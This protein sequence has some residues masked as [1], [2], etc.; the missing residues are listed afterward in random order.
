M[1]KQ[2]KS[3]PKEVKKKQKGR[4]TSKTAAG[5]TNISQET[6]DAIINSQKEGAAL[7]EKSLKQYKGAFKNARKWVQ[8]FD[9]ETALQDAG[10]MDSDLPPE[11]AQSEFQPGHHIR[12]DPE[13]HS[14][15]N[16]IYDPD[17]KKSLDGPPTRT[18]PAAMA[19]Y[20]S[21]QI[22]DEGFGRSTL[23]MIDAAFKNHYKSMGNGRYSKGE[24]RP[25]DGGLTEEYIGCP[26]TANEYTA[27]VGHLK[28]KIVE[29]GD[30]RHHSQPMTIE[31]VRKLMAY[32]LEKCP[33][34]LVDDLDKGRIKAEDFNATRL[35]VVKHL[36]F[37]AYLTTGWTLWTRCSELADLR[38]ADITFGHT[39]PKRPTS[40]SIWRK[41]ARVRMLRRKGWTLK[42]QKG[43]SMDDQ[44]IRGHA[45]NI[46]SDPPEGIEVDSY[47]HLMVWRDFY[48]NFYLQTS[49]LDPS[50][51]VF[52]FFHT[53]SG[54]I[55]RTKGCSET[56]MTLLKEFAVAA[57]LV[58]EG[59]PNF[60][61]TTHCLRRGGAQ[62]RFMYAPIGYRW[63]LQVIRWWGGWAEN[64]QAR[65]IGPCSVAAVI[66]PSFRLPLSR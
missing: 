4:S 17:F 66:T 37:R 50:L 8:E 24:W 64:E 26:G 53:L 27:L 54:E 14:T 45:Y 18:T 34:S 33:A 46:F 6:R 38:W 41:C 56:F 60:P 49:V 10:R 16:V 3:K 32:S 5:S 59:E 20:L 25:K 31:A 2:T 11:A 15:Y 43:V 47:V 29:R 39:P 1:P 7:S 21:H 55:N 12:Y 42:L 13:L 40:R 58:G 35:L 44:R 30:T 28:K 62:Y 51:H 52:P 65:T 48:Q 9:T 23:D 22:V 61:F 19:V 57:G 63:P 36:W